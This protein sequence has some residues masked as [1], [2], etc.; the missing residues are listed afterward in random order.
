MGRYAWWRDA[1]VDEDDDDDENDVPKA[2]EQTPYHVQVLFV[3]CQ[4]TTV[5]IA[6]IDANDDDECDGESG[7]DY[8]FGQYKEEARATQTNDG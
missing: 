2:R 7:T 4:D 8:H 1:G 5:A 6:A 3:Y